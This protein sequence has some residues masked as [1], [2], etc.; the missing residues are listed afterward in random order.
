[1]VNRY[2][3]NVTIAPPGHVQIMK[4]RLLLPIATF[5]PRISILHFE[6]GSVVLRPSGPNFTSPQV[7][8]WATSGLQS[9]DLS[10]QA[11]L[12]TIS[13]L[14]KHLLIV[15]LFSHPPNKADSILSS[16]FPAFLRFRNIFWKSYHAH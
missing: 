12:K 15:M 10:H 3:E 9:L 5:N 7:S 13:T 4:L 8:G 1:M 11:I 14:T 16:L 2:A 6:T